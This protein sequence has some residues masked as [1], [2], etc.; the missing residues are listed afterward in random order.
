MLPTTQVTPHCE[1]PDSTIDLADYFAHL[2]S[3]GDVC[4][5]AT[6]PHVLPSISALL[7]HLLPSWNLTTI[8]DARPDAVDFS[9]FDDVVVQ[10]AYYAHTST[11]TALRDSLSQFHVFNQ[12][13]RDIIR[14]APFF[15]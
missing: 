3:P 5:P 4:S 10:F 9:A 6:V 1:S 7:Q 2:R 11:V 13:F 15:A 8:D 12:Q 14:V